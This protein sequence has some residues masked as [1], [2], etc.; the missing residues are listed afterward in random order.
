MLNR[1]RFLAAA[2]VLPFPGLR[3][4]TAQHGT[5]IMPHHAWH[6]LASAAVTMYRLPW[7]NQSVSADSATVMAH[8]MESPEQWVYYRDLYFGIH[9]RTPEMDAGRLWLTDEHRL[10]DLRAFLQRGDCAIEDAGNR[11]TLY[12]EPHLCLVK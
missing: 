4:A 12:R 1:R 8:V 6:A 9:E 5:F 2:A 7:D 10:Q 11:V 3:R